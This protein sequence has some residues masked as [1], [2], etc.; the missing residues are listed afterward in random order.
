MASQGKQSSM[1]AYHHSSCFDSDL[2]LSSYHRNCQSNRHVTGSGCGSGKEEKASEDAFHPCSLMIRD[3]DTEREDSTLTDTQSVIRS[4]A[5]SA[6]DDTWI[7]G[8]EQREKRPGLGHTSLVK[9]DRPLWSS[10]PQ[11][12]LPQEGTLLCSS[13]PHLLTLKT[14]TSIIIPLRPSIA[15]DAI[16][17]T[18]TISIFTLGEG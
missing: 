12:P 13:R 8:D 9:S 17:K 15:K 2:S 4:P 3:E 16:S 7:C 6:I 5:Y 11:R 18:C 10:Q 14:I 1:L